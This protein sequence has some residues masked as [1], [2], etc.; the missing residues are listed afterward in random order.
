MKE[1]PTQT[2]PGPGPPPSHC[3]A[4]PRQEG[5]TARWSQSRTEAQARRG[6]AQA[7]GTAD[8]FLQASTQPGVAVG[9]L[10]GLL[11]PVP[12]FR[13]EQFL[14]SWGLVPAPR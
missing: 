10:G 11:V 8:R 12:L 5:H 6:W 14:Q 1:P 9:H 7:A 3:A 4:V 2:G 13:R